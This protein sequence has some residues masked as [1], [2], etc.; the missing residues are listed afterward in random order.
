MVSRQ[1]LRVFRR[2]RAY[3]GR[4]S[5]A[6]DR[7]YHDWLFGDQPVD[8]FRR[9]YPGNVTILRFADLTAAHL[10]AATHV[11]DL[12]CGPGEITCEL[13]R[14]YPGTRFEGI[15]HSHVG[16]TRAR[17]HAER[18]DLKNIAFRVADVE[19]FAPD[20][21]VDL[22][23]MFDSFHHITGPGGFVSRMSRFSSRFLLIE[24]RGDWAERWSKEVDL[25][26]LVHDL[27]KI[28]TRLPYATGESEPPSE[29][30]SVD[31][32]EVEEPVEHRYPPEDFER[33]FAGFGLEIRGT[34]A[35][36]DGYPPSPELDTPT[37]ERF[38][39]LAYELYKEADDLFRERDLDL[40]AK[41]LVI[42]AERGTRTVHRELAAAPPDREWAERIRGPYDARYLAYDGLR[43]A[44]TEKDLHA[45]VTLRN[46]GWRPWS[47]VLEEGP[48]FVSYHWLD[49]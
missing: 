2:A 38:G 31:P 7:A 8:P 40:F 32:P 13:A 48:D 23:V 25:D 20:G 41:Q 26:W 42:Y 11:L 21:P 37:R 47:S 28:R 19:R 44:G 30:G 46:E 14:R 29:P 39:E 12:G 22:I 3:W 17:A 24:P 16:I 27:E 18:L 36:L 15:D 6:R 45:T 43:E 5:P 1:I 9:S 10:G 34:V 35:G 33:W 4:W 49:R